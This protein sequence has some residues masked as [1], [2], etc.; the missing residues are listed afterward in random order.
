ML[1]I[2]V[3]MRLKIIK[4]IKKGFFNIKVLIKHIEEII[5]ER[6]KYRKVKRN[7]THK[8]LLIELII[9]MLMIVVKSFHV[10]KIIVGM[11]T[12]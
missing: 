3:D 6:Q 5:T 8:G 11:I 4:S 9:L 2:K 12:Q 1:L 10:C 7:T